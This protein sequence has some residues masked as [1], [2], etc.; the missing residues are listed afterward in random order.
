[1]KVGGRPVHVEQG[2]KVDITP[3]RT[4]DPAGFYFSDAYTTK[5]LQYLDERMPEE[6][7]KPFFSYLAFSAPHWPNQSPKAVREKYIP[8]YADG[9]LELRKR[10]LAALVKEGIIDPEV[11]PHEVVSPDVE[12]EQMSEYEQQCSVRSMAAY[13]GMVEQMDSNIGRV[14]D[15]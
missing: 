12:W 7:Q 6:R 11:I 2:K 10:R 1:M 15:S 9:P 13:A 3:N 8:L 14:V 5:L 4:E